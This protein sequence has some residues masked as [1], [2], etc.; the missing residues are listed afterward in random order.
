MYCSTGVSKRSLP[1]RCTGLLEE[2]DV[3]QRKA[4]LATRLQAAREY[5]RRFFAPESVEATVRVDPI[6]GLPVVTG[7]ITLGEPSVDESRRGFTSLD[8]LPRQADDAMR[9]LNF[10]VWI[11][12]DRLD[13]AFARHE[14]LETNALRALFAAY[15][16]MSGLKHIRPKIFLRS[17]I[18][19]RIS[20]GKFAEGSHIDEERIEWKAL[21]LR[22]LMLRRILRNRPIANFYAVDPDEVFASVEKQEELLGRMFPTQ[23]D[24]GNNPRAFDWML[25]RTQD[26][27]KQTAPR[28]LI[29]LLISLGE[30]QLRRLE[31][32]HEPPP[33]ENLFE[34]AVFKEALE[35]VSEVRLKKTLYS[36]Y[37]DL[38]AYVELLRGEKAQQS[39]PTLSLIWDA[40]EAATRKIA[41]RLVQVGYFERL[42]SKADPDYWVPFLYRDASELVQGRAK[43]A[44]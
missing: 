40:D 1:V 6:T 18:W 25:T 22:Q 12:L 26:G 30:R 33:D 11:V 4:T 31:L 41:D 42:G 3:L 19:D 17:D 7:K 27:S 15:L 35:D 16:D 29:H 21:G 13:V 38:K 36:E 10:T 5:A 8:Q 37:P 9:E 2:A 28:E 14:E 23:I 24:S 34:R 43:L 44:P 39:L 20:D 32:G